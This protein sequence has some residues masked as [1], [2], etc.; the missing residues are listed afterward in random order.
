M[1][2]KSNVR[3][4]PAEMQRTYVTG[5]MSIRDLA[6]DV[7]L[8]FSAVAS[9]ARRED[10]YA[11]REAYKDSVKRRT[12][13]HTADRFAREQAEIRTENIVALRATVRTFIAQLNAGEIKVS[14]KDA[15]EA[16]KTIGL[17]LGDPTSRSESKI[18]EFTTGGLEPDFLRE[19][20]RIS[21]AQIVEGTVAGPPPGLPEGAIED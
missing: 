6:K 8:S 2:V 21:R 3:I 20:V 16:V 15:I 19:L 18:V 17:Y 10:W 1:A 5:E 7:G 13:E 9:R 14:P 12:Y 4:D 11:K